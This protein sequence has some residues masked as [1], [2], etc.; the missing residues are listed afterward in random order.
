MTA[1]IILASAVVAFLFFLFFQVW[2]RYFR[3]AEVAAAQLIPVDL[4]AFEN[5]TDP[6]EVRFLRNHL[7]PQ[8]FRA[9][10]RTRIHAAKVYVAALSENAGVLVS[11]GQ[12]ARSQPDPEVAAAG[13]DIVQR[14]IKLKVWCLFSLLQLNAALLFP[15]RMAPTNGITHRYL[16][17]TYMAAN[18]GAK[19]AA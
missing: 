4:E 18:L 7:P 14:A 8:Q 11:L 9:I 10:Q 16:L 15:A 17:V 13:V 1:L 2:R 12:S 6:E 19:S 5:L 3:P